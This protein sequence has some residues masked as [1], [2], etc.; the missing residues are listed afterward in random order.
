M[1]ETCGCCEGIERLTPI[2]IINRPGLDALVYRVGTHAS[3]LE[4][5]LA[6]L[7]NLGIP[8]KDLEITL[9]EF[10]DPN[11]Q[12]YPL[13]GLTTRAASDPAIAFLDAWATVAD[14]LTFYQERIANEGYLRTATER[15]SILELARLVGYTL[16]P[17]VAASV[18][19]AYTLEK[20]HDVTILPRNRAQSVPGPGELPQSFE[21]AEPLEARFIWNTLQPRLTSLPFIRLIPASEASPPTGEDNTIDTDT[22]YFL[23][24][25]TRLKPGDALLFVFNDLTGGFPFIFDDVP[26][27]FA[28]VKVTSVE[29]QAVQNRTKVMIDR[30]LQKTAMMAMFLIGSPPSSPPE[31]PATGGKLSFTGLVKTLTEPPSLSPR[32]SQ[33]L[34]RRVG[35]IFNPQ[36]GIN[37]LILKTINPALGDTLD[38]AL[39]NADVSPTPSS[40]PSL[41]CAAAL[42]VKAALFGHN[43]PLP[44][45]VKPQVFK[46]LIG[47]AFLQE[48]AQIKAFFQESLEDPRKFLPLDAQYDQITVGSWI[49]VETLDSTGKAVRTFH[50]VIDV[51]TVT[52]TPLDFLS[53]DVFDGLDGA[54]LQQILAIL[55]VAIKITLLKIDPSWLPRPTAETDLFSLLRTTTIYAQS[56]CLPL[57][58]V[59]LANNP[60]AQT[61]QGMGEE[62]AC[63]VKGNL[64]ELDQL[65]PDLK[66]GRRIVVSGERADVSGTSG[67]RVSELVMLAGV[68]QDVSTVKVDGVDIPLPGDKLHTFLQLATPLSYTYKCDTVTIYGNVVRATHGETRTEVLGSGDGSKALQRF[69]LRQLPLTYLSAPTAAGAES[70]L[71]VRVNDIL[72]HEADSLADLVPTDRSYTTESDDADK[73]TVI[74]GN[75]RYGARLPTGVENVK[76]VYRTGIGKPG[77]V[78]AGQITL[79]ATKPLG[80]KGVINPLR[81]SGGAD[82]ESR[83][84]ARRNVPLALLA[85]DRL[86]SVEDYEDFARTYAGIG[87]ASAA[88]ISNRRR[89]L[90][91][92][93]IVGADNIPIDK[94]SDLYLN[95][96]QALLQLGDPNVPLQVDLC[97]VMFIVISASVRLLP[98]YLWESVE[99]NIRAALLDFFG[100]ERRELGQPVFESEVF[101]V[102]QGIAG[103]DYVDLEVLGAVDQG[104][105]VDALDKASQTPPDPSDPKET[106]TEEF[107][108]LLD[109]KGHKNIP[110]GLAFFNPTTSSIVPA[111]LAFLSPDVPDMLILT[112]IAQ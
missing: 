12:I 59:P 8:R 26:K 70:T 51:Q 100:F 19:L 6:R 97:E 67:V 53:G 99:A 94:N 9:S 58:E 54:T 98:D 49:V 27:S 64:I 72:W 16:R 74:F 69:S 42:R 104:K 3:F 96:V 78:Q 47:D 31:P 17:G 41:D 55:T 28:F 85:L 111:Q 56:E 48:G 30:G 90:V 63:I 77:N 33:Q 34:Q 66:S 35:Q 44:S 57:S 89:R 110:V 106:V 21:T 24:I 73:T 37:S 105:V 15:R 22:I 61:D 71:R 86:V 87:K 7:S 14:V 79:L 46:R 102:I 52:L 20:D 62:D 91:H 84:S 109:L 25:A 4:T 76:A 29:P 80:V 68:T 81:A 13:Q 2:A 107:L 32:N 39:S 93:S 1:N 38:A 60:A 36:S 92:L 65:Y 40:I 112:E 82:R 10:D 103:V 18:F 5:M 88:H 23:G 95:L 108:E 75:G 83:D 45:G 43:L 50:Q 11:A 101:S